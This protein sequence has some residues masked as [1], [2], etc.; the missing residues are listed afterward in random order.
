MLIM[1]V[2]LVLCHVAER[3]GKL[4][5]LNSRP[6]TMHVKIANDHEA[7]A[8]LGLNT[9]Y[10]FYSGSWAFWSDADLNMDT[11]TIRQFNKEKILTHLNITSEKAA[12]F[13]V[14]AG[15]LFSSE[16]NINTMVTFFRPWTKQLFSNVAKF[17]NE[18]TFPISDSS[19]ASIITKIFGQC[20]DKLFYDFKRTLRLMDP[21]TCNQVPSE[22]DPEV[23]KLIQD[24]YANLAE[25]IFENSPI[26]ISP[27]YL[28][29]R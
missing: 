26:Y 20:T 10:I 17:V 7:M 2:M 9:H 5:G 1:I 24:D 22:V 3:Y 21:T 28:D 25:E 11:M 27:V 16:A 29:L 14:L 18:Q 23:M 13:A 4:Y 12:L 15:S 19:L 8:L 6:S